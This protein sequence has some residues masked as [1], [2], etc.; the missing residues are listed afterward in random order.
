MAV[1]HHEHYMTSF[2]LDYINKHKKKW[3]TQPKIIYGEKYGNMIILVFGKPRTAVLAHMDEVGFMV[4]NKNRLLKVGNTKPR[5]GDKLYGYNENGDRVFATIDETKKKIKY[6]AKKK[7][8]IGTILSFCPNWKQTNKYITNNAH[9]DCVGILILLNL[10]KKLKNGVLIFT[11]QEETSAGK[12]LG[13]I[14]KYIYETCK[15]NQVLI[16]DVTSITQEGIE[17]NQ[18]PVIGVGVNEMPSPFYLS[19]IT[20][21][22]GNNIDIQLEIRETG[23]SDFSRLLYSPYVFNICFIGCPIEDKHSSH[24]KISINDVS[25]MLKVYSKLMKYL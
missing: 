12:N 17:M 4:G 23:S 13:V 21:I 9:D 20:N 6:K 18:G 10:A 22:I 3:K 1:S 7:L 19:K 16:A 2:L 11:T 8:P 15:I 5:Y 14:A 24:E 25:N